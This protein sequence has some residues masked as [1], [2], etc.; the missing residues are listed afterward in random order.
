[1][2]GES[3]PFSRRARSI[4][5]VAATVI[6]G[7]VVS[8][9]AGIG[10]VGGYL[11]FELGC[12][13]LYD[14]RDWASDRVRYPHAIAMDRELSAELA[15]K[16]D[17][18]IASFRLG[19]IFHHPVRRACMETWGA[20]HFGGPAYEL[21]LRSDR[22]WW[23]TYE[24]GESTITVEFADGTIRALRVGAQLRSNVHG[25]LP[26]RFI[27]EQ[28]GKQSPCAPEGRLTFTRD[29]SH[30]GV[31]FRVT[32]THRLREGTATGMVRRGG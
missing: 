7:V 12:A 17:S 31:A 16:W 6:G 9:V 21:A 10:V 28:P 3:P 20:T 8:L 15:E 1:M 22:P 32:G 4:A 30:R 19:D 5:V 11:L 23:W 18:G 2:A 27:F 24:N 14:T 25:H 26:V 13:M 29:G